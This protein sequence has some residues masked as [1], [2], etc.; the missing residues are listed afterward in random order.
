MLAIFSYLTGRYFF[1]VSLDNE[2]TQPWRTLAERTAVNQVKKFT[3]VTGNSRSWTA[4]KFKGD[5]WNIPFDDEEGGFNPF[6]FQNRKFYKN[7][8]I[9]R[10][11]NFK[12]NVKPRSSNRAAEM[13]VNLKRYSVLKLGEFF[14][15]KHRVYR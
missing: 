7:N 12:K 9:R 8:R 13:L 14:S 2:R 11:I 1:Y 3:Y 10:T 6:F 4:R 15:I 5:R